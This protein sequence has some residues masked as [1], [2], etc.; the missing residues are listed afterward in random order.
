MKLVKLQLIPIT[1]IHVGTGEELDPLGYT[2]HKGAVYLFNVRALNRFFLEQD[3]LEWKRVLEQG[4]LL[5][6]RTHIYRHFDPEA[7]P[8]MK[9]RGAG[10]FLEEFVEK[11][12]TDGN[13]QL[14][15]HPLPRA[16]ETAPAYLP[17]S[18]IKGALRTALLSGLDHGRKPTRGERNWEFETLGAMN[19]RG[20]PDMTADPFKCLGVPDLPLEAGSTI[21]RKATNTG[22][23]GDGR[24]DLAFHVESTAHNGL[25]K[26]FLKPEVA[27]ELDL[28]IND[29]LIDRGTPDWIADPAAWL[30][31]CNAHAGDVLHHLGERFAWLGESIEI[32]REITETEGYALLRLGRFSGFFGVSDRHLRDLNQ[33]HGGSVTLFGG[34]R[35]ILPGWLAVKILE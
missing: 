7:I 33:R 6:I 20:R 1:P 15:F 16:G 22:K 31:L 35:K 8:H 10:K 14:L 2:V 27:W 26:D 13:N 21:V 25:G 30:K 23:F 12:A 19:D 24:S 28:R 29:A 34:G 17:G 18:S 11:I 3:P 4:S 9:I 32:L 5:A